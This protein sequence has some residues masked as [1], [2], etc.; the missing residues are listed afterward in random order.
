MEYLGLFILF[1]GIEL[2][3]FKIADLFDVDVNYFLT[4][5]DEFI[6]DAREKYGSIGEKDARELIRNASS[7]FAG[8]SLSEADKEAV[9][10]ALQEAYYTAKREN[11]KYAPKKFR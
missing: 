3:Y 11:K 1:I 5:G 4:V 10:L 7:L 8:G 6:Q 2:I 9:L